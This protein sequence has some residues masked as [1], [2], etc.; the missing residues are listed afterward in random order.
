[1]DHHDCKIFFQQPLAI[2]V[3]EGKKFNLS[4]FDILP[5]KCSRERE[6]TMKYKLDKEGSNRKSC[7]TDSE[8]VVR[9]MNLEISMRSKWA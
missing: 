2:L 1:M 3:K 9:S 6:M 8:K 7:V 4:E 5:G